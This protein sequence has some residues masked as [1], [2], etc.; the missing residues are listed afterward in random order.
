MTAPNEAV[1]EQTVAWTDAECAALARL[2]DL[3]HVRPGDPDPT[4]WGGCFATD[5]STVDAARPY[6]CSRDPHVDGQHIAGD[7]LVVLAV[8][9]CA[10]SVPDPAALR[11]HDDER[12]AA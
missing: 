11:G 2:L 4:G 9:P 10:P 3:D 8:W 5:A 12:G 6:V 1:T 7:G